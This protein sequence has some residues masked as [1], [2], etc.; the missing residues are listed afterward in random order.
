MSFLTQAFAR[1]GHNASKILCFRVQ[2]PH[3]A[4]YPGQ[5]LKKGDFNAANNWFPVHGNAESIGYFLFVL[6]CFVL[7]CFV[8]FCFLLLWDP[9]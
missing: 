3:V 4:K 1:V 9:S 6:F 8:L 5:E 2:F 7:F